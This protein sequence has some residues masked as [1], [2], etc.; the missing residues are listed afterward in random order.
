MAFKLAARDGRT[1]IMDLELGSAG[2][3][4]DQWYA[5][6]KDNSYINYGAAV[7]HEFARATVLDGYKPVRGDAIDALTT[8]T[9]N[10]WTAQQPTLSRGRE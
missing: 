3:H 2:N 5:D 8:R 10:G 7:S 9:K 4:M 1:T 6:R